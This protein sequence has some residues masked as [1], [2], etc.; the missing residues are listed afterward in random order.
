[1]AGD[2]R[3][4]GQVVV[5]VDV[6]IGAGARRNRVQ[7]SQRETGAVVIE[8]RIQPG[9]GAVTRIASLGEVRRDVIGI[10]RS[11]IVL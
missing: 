1:M 5:V 7:A 3:R 10:R 2:A 6:A 11:L 9:T 4:A 8:R